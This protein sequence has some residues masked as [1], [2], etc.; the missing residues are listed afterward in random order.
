MPYV[1]IALFAAA[2]VGVSKIPVEIDTADEALD[3]LCSLFSLKKKGY[4]ET[5]LLMKTVGDLL[6][7]AD[8][9]LINYGKSFED[10]LQRE[11]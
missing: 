2:G 4:R 8:W 10:Y 9:A 6:S 3:N 5:L 7:V 11:I 1:L